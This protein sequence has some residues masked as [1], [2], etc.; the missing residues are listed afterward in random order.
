MPASPI[1]NANADD[2]T[3]DSITSLYIGPVKQLGLEH[4]EERSAKTTLLHGIL[5]G[6]NGSNY[7]PGSVQQVSSFTFYLDNEKIYQDLTIDPYELPPPKTT[8][9]LLGCYTATVHDSFPILSRKLLKDQVKNYFK[10]LQI[11]NSIRL[12]PKWQG[13]MNLVFAISAKYLNLAGASWCADERDHLIYYA[14]ARAFGLNRSTFIKYPDVP[15]IQLVGLL[16]FYYL[17]IGHIKRL[18]SVITGR[19]SIIVDSYYSVPLPVPLS[20]EQINGPELIRI[21]NAGSPTANYS[22]AK[23]PASE[24]FSASTID[25]APRPTGKGAAEANSGS[26]FKATVQIAIVTQN[27][28]SSLYSIR[29]IIQS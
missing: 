2:S 21:R 6:R 24:G 9:H 1:L 29:T 3:R 23:S 28:L 13:I 18:L 14:R 22:S 15:Q 8:E 5:P 10:S 4:T 16:A 20:E 12:S 17:S 25:A 27:I 7:R 11:G 26:Y 19:P